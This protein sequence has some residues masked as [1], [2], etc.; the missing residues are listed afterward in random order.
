LN[1]VP[2]ADSVARCPEAGS[3]SSRGAGDRAGQGGQARTGGHFDKMFLLQHKVITLSQFASMVVSV[4][5]KLCR[6]IREKNIL[7]RRF[8]LVDALTLTLFMLNFV[9]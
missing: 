2:V 4:K 6:R 5:Y 9:V 3:D 7:N 1:S 8:A